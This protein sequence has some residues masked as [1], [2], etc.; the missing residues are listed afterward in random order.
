MRKNDG[1]ES[2]FKKKK[3]KKIVSSHPGGSVS[4]PGVR[5]S[6]CISGRLSDDLGGS[7]MIWEDSYVWTVQVPLCWMGY[8]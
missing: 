6:G 5:E 8:Q 7:R 1:L 2:Y 4:L 3:K